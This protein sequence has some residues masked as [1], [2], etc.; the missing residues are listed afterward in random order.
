MITFMK[1]DPQSEN[2]R[3]QGKQSEKTVDSEMY[4]GKLRKKVERTKKKNHKSKDK[5][6]VA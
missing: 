2:T 4:I 3:F 1:E 6:E 5:L